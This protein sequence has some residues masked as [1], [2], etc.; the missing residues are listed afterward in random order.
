MAGKRQPWKKDLV[1]GILRAL[2][3]SKRGLWIRKLARVLGEPV[4][5]VRKYIHRQDY[6]G[7]FVNTKRLP[8][9]E[10]GRLII[11]LK[12]GKK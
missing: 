7:R 10:G 8:Y 12:G 5:T 2:G 11:T 6:C 1:N 9:E 3:K 4:P